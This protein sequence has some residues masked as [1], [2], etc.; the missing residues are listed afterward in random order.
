MTSVERQVCDCPEPCGCYAEGHSADRG[1]VAKYYQGSYGSNHSPP[2]T[3]LIA[4]VHGHNR[5]Q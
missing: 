4:S 1:A 2:I 3:S 5:D